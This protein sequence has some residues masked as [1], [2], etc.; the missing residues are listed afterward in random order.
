MKAHVQFHI[1][2]FV[3]QDSLDLLGLWVHLDSILFSK[4]VK[5]EDM[6]HKVIH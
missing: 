3:T 5:Y 1:F 4:S 6:F 2:T